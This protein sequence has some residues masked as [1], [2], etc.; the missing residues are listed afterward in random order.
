MKKY[1]ALLFI[2]ALMVG[3]GLAYFF[4][5][6]TPVTK[7][8]PKP[9]PTPFAADRYSIPALTANPPKTGTL[10]VSGSLFEFRFQPDPE[11][12]EIKKI[13]DEW[14]KACWKW[15]L[16][17]GVKKENLRFREHEK[18][19]LSHYALDTAKINESL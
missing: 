14:K 6:K 17:L 11:K 4:F 7:F 12:K 16:D 19:E 3:S 18:D 5:P 9:T 13:F 10:T 8:I 1:I 15:Y 2:L